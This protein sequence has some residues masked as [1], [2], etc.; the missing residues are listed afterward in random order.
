MITVPAM[1][2]H[3][4]GVTFYQA[5]L[6]VSDV[7]KLVRF[8][9]LSYS[10][11]RVSGKK[12]KK[13]TARGAKINWELLDNSSL[14]G[15]NGEAGDMTI[16]LICEPE[17]RPSKTATDI[18]DTTA[19]TNLSSLGQSLHQSNLGLSRRLV[20]I[21]ITVVKMFA[22]KEAIQTRQAIVMLSN[23]IGLDGKLR[24]GR[25][26]SHGFLSAI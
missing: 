22:P 20:V 2:L 24:R 14:D 11:Q 12:P 9:V 6:S 13:T 23:M 7:Q 25:R 16:Q 15:T 10:G 19:E 26:G 21:P 18:E 4:F 17:C 1:R 5:I 3:Q 8:E